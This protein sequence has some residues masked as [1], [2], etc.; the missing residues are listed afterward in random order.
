VISAREGQ[1][2]WELLCELQRGGHNGASRFFVTDETGNVLSN[3][4]LD[5]EVSQH[6]WNA[7]TKTI[8]FWNWHF[9]LADGP[10]TI[11][12]WRY[13]AQPTLTKHALDHNKMFELKGGRYVAKAVAAK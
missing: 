1:D 2:G 4:M 3:V 10:T 5:A 9:N 13:G 6:T 8:V 7:R 11:Q 12:V